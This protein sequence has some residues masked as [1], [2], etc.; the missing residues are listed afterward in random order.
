MV[1]VRRPWYAL[2]DGRHTRCTTA[3]AHIV[4]RLP[5]I[6]RYIEMRAKTVPKRLDGTI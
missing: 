6:Y 1:V 2:Y 3:V 5:N 4:W